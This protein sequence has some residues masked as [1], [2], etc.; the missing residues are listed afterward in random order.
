VTISGNISA[1]SVGG[2]IGYNTG[3]L[4]K[5]SAIISGALVSSAYD[6]GGLIGKNVNPGEISSSYAIIS[7]NISAN[8]ESGGVAGYNGGKISNSSATVSGK[9][10]VGGKYAGGFVGQ[11]AASGTISNSSA[12]ISGNI[13]A[14]SESAGGFVGFNSQTTTSNCFAIISGRISATSNYAGGFVGWNTVLGAITNSYA[15]SETTSYISSSQYAGGF[16]GYRNSGSIS[17][18]YAVRKGTGNGFGFTGG[19]SSTITRSYYDNSVFLQDAI[20]SGVNS[21]STNDMQLQS[22][23]SLWDFINTWAIDTNKNNGYP[24]LKWQ[25]L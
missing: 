7:G 21:K 24:Y 25:A 9:V 5:A 10:S 8:Y 11:T 20:S 17:N 22:T 12:T 1:A 4:S 2:L 14:T 18:C 19:S 15:K 16:V 23:Y 13:S 3:A 6:A